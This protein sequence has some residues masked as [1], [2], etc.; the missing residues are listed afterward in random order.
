MHADLDL[1]CVSV[2]VTADDLL[3]CPPVTP[4]AS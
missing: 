3:R 1:L 4:A 2:Y